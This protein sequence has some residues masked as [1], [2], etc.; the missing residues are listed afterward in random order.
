MNCS[1][2]TTP[3][4][5][6]LL[7]ISW[8]WTAELKPPHHVPDSSEFSRKWSAHQMSSLF[9]SSCD[10]QF[11]QTV[12]QGPLCMRNHAFFFFFFYWTLAIFIEM[13]CWLNTTP[14][15][16]GLVSCLQKTF[17]QC[18]QLFNYWN[19]LL[20]MDLF[21]I[22]DFRRHLT[23]CQKLLS[24]E[25]A[26]LFTWF[27]LFPCKRFAH[28]SLPSLETSFCFYECHF[29][30]LSAYRRQSTWATIPLFT[31][32]IPLQE[33]NYSPKIIWEIIPLF[34]WFSISRNELLTAVHLLE[35]PSLF[36]FDFP[37]Q[38]M[39]CSPQ[40]I[41][42]RDHFSFSWLFPVSEM[43]CLA[44][45]TFMRGHPSSYLNT[46]YKKWTAYQIPWDI[47]PLFIW[48]AISR[49]KLLS[50]DSLTCSF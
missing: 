35:R 12:H 9:Q 25:I 46:H 4:C 50:K 47:I 22:L 37:F 44:K 6:W 33:M 14:P 2:K 20:T 15:F 3:A 39:N 26:P 30:K 38:G 7:W 45:T 23:A 28:Q 27:I 29:K 40:S 49:N 36:L 34:I 19:E 42:L 5:T 48:S 17:S 21:S 31:W 13:N 10:F 11:P 16:T 24:R 43:T 18:A 1:P 32:L 8:E 41:F